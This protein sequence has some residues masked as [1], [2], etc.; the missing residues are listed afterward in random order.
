MKAEEL[1]TQ[2]VCTCSAD[3]SLERAAHIMWTSDVGCLVVTN[4]EQEPI[5][6][7][8]DRDIAMAAYTQGALLRDARVGS[9]MSRGVV[10]CSL[11]TSLSELEAKMRTAQIRRIPVLDSS[12]K[13]AGIVALADI[14]RSAQSSPLKMSEIPGLAKTLAGITERRSEPAVAAQ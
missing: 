9:A 1:M 6:M 4:G 14:A 13:L 10:S 3:D 11:G 8:T 2:D 5:G 12:G 7:I